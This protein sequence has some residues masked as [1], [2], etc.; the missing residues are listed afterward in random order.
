M[1]QERI[2]QLLGL[3]SVA[4][5]V[6]F[7]VCFSHVLKVYG[8]SA[9]AVGGIIGTDFLSISGWYLIYKLHE[10]GFA[11]IWLVLFAATFA[12]NTLLALFINIHALFA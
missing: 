8:S 2:D 1:K 5:M 4:Q 10:E 12:L 11:K 6:L 7:V 9:E 3:L